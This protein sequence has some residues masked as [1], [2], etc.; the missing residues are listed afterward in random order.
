MTGRRRLA[1]RPAADASTAR[2]PAPATVVPMT[3]RTDSPG[4][5]DAQ[6][7]TPVRDRWWFTAALYAVAGMAVALY[8]VVPILNGEADWLNWLVGLVGLA[9]VVISIRA[10]AISR[11]R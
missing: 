11:P 9:L 8:Q 5:D 6:D 3:D 10:W 4:R 2:E 1:A 7:R